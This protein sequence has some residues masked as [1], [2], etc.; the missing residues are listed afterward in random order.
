MIGEWTLFSNHGHVLFCLAKNNDARLRD[1]AATVGITERAVQKIVRELQDA[2][3]VAVTKHGRCNRYRINTRKPLRHAIEADCTVGRLLQAVV[4]DTPGETHVERSEGKADSMPGKAAEK[5]Q[6]KP[7][8]AT[9]AEARPAA[10]PAEKPKKPK[11]ADRGT[12][13]TREGPPDSSQQG[14]LF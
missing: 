7:E 6:R 2:G 13:R 1:V 8:S 4:G 9:T 11:P 14:N 5:P 3:F 10:R 12:T